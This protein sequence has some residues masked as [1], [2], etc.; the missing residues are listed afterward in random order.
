MAA[1]THIRD[2]SSRWYCCAFERARLLSSTKVST[3]S[4]MTQAITDSM[5]RG[6]VPSPRSSH[7][8]GPVPCSSTLT[9]LEVPRPQVTVWS[10]LWR[11]VVNL[12]VC[13]L[14]HQMKVHWSTY[15]VAGHSTPPQAS[16]P[17]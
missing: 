5:V 13:P 8:R 11:K 14:L 10:I 7:I 4:V 17:D 9:E 3:F 15:R 16:A 2:M 6:Q 1:T 12:R